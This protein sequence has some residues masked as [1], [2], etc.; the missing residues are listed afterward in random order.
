[1]LLRGIAS[2]RAAAAAADDD[3]DDEA[4]MDSKAGT[5]NSLARFLLSY[6]HIHTSIS[7]DI[8]AS[9]QY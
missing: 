6:R 4:L 1:M 8:T 2:E 5:E 7:S 3:D 9:V